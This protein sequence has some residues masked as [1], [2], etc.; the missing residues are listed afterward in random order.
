[1]NEDLLDLDMEHCEEEELM[2]E[3]E[4]PSFLTMKDLADTL[5]LLGGYL[6]FSDDNPNHESSAKVARLMK[7]ASACFGSFTGKAALVGAIFIGQVV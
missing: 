1:L 6:A 7:E 4:S 5:K 2:D 3:D